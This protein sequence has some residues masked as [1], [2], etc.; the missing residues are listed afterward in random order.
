MVTPLSDIYNTYATPHRL[1]PLLLPFRYRGPQRLISFAIN[2]GVILNDYKIS[3]KEIFVIT[4][5]AQIVFAINY[6]IATILKWQGIIERNRENINNNYDFQSLVVFFQDKQLPFW[7]FYP[8]QNINITEIIH[9]LV[10][11]FGF[12]WIAK[13]KFMKAFLFTLIFYG[14]ALLIWIIFTIFLQTTLF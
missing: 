1:H 8:L 3:I 9:L 4:L 6:L 13:I 2:I 11:S 7:K 5:K 10:L 12:A 14:L